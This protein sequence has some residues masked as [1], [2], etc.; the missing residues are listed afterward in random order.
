[1]VIEKGA[2]VPSAVMVA[3]A[4]ILAPVMGCPI[5]NPL[6]LCIFVRILLPDVAVPVVETVLEALAFADIVTVFVARESVLMVV[7]TA[8]PTP[9]VRGCPTTNPVVVLATFVMFALPLVTMP[10]NVT[11]FVVGLE[12]EAGPD[13]V[14][15][16]PMFVMVVPAVMPV[17]VTTCPVATPEVLPTGVMVE[18]PLLR[19]PVNVTKGVALAACD[20]VIVVPL[21]AT[22]VVAGLVGMPLPVMV[23]PT[24][25]PEMLE[26]PV[27]VELPEVL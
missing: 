21:A 10:L 26:T 5:S 12:A 14:R 3:P 4:G 20:I 22:I 25:S 11:M 19:T 2:V 8:M 18:L 1:M 16:L 9:A 15:L 27:M 7:P 6:V 24:I 17:P 23:C 13:N